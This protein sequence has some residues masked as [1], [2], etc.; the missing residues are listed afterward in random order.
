VTD[1]RTSLRLL[2]EKAR[3][4]GFSP[5]TSEASVFEQ[6]VVPLLRDVLG[7]RTDEITEFDRQ[8]YSRGAGIADGVLKL[9]GSPALYIEAKRIGRIPP[10]SELRRRA[11]FYSREEEQ[12]IRYARRSAAMR[13]GERWTVLTDFFRL[14]V[15]EASREERVLAF[16]SPEELEERFDEL[17]LLSRESVAGGRLH[18]HHIAERKPDIDTEFRDSLLHWRQRL[19]QQLYDSNPDRFQ[20]SGDLTIRDLQS[21]VQ[22]LLDRLIIIQFAAD[23]DAL[24]GDDPLRDLLDRVAP[25][26]GPRSLVQ[27]PSLRDALFAAFRRFDEFYNTSLF[28][29]GHVLESLIIE[30]AI[31]YPL[32]ESMAGQSFRRLDADILGT[33]YETYLGHRLR[34]ANGIVSMEGQVATRRA[35]GVY[36]T[37]V[38][39]VRAI[40]ERTVG[41]RLASVRDASEVDDIKVLDPACGSGSFLIQAFDRFAEW[42]EAENARR[43]TALPIAPTMEEVAAGPIAD[44]GRRILENNL[45]GVDLDPEAIELAAVN[46]ILQ[47]MRRGT[48]GVHLGRLPLILGQNLKVGNSLVPGYFR[49]KPMQTSAE[50]LASAADARKALQRTLH[51]SDETLALA[52][53]TDAS[54]AAS[55]AATAGMADEYPEIETRQPFWWEAEFPEVFSRAR[56]TADRG[57]AVVVGNPPWIG[58]QG[59]VQDRSYLAR[60]YESATGRFDIYVPFLELASQLTRD[61]G[62]VGMVTPSTYFL[63]D[64]GRT[65]RERLRDGETIVEII[66]YGSRQLF[67][68]ATNYPAIIILRRDRP[69]PTHEVLYVLD[70]SVGDAAQPHRQA[71]LRSEGWVFWSAAEAELFGHVEALA[72]TEPLEDICRLAGGSSGL[73]EGVV[74]GQNAVFLVD[75]D[76][77][78]AEGFEEDVMRPCVKGTD[79]ERWSVPPPKRQLIYPYSAGTVLSEDELARRPNVHR[80]LDAHRAVASPAGGL[81]GR[82]YMDGSTKRWYELWNQRSEALLSAPKLLTPE[83]GSRPKFALVDAEIA[84]TDSVTSA[85]PSRE[86]GYCREYLAGILNSRLMTLLHARMSVPKANGYLIF[87]PAFLGRLPIRRPNLDHPKDRRLHKGMVTHV[88]ECTELAASMRTADLDFQQY[89]TAYTVTDRTLTK[90]LSR[91]APEQRRSLAQVPGQLLA[92]AARREG[93][94]LVVTG[95]AKT[96]SLS[97]AGSHD[98]A[99]RDLLRLHV[100]EPLASFLEL[101]LP[102]ATKFHGRPNRHRTLSSRAS[103]MLLPDMNEA[104]MQDAVDKYAAEADRVARAKR[105]LEVLEGEI[106]EYVAA[107][108]ELTPAMADTVARFVLP[109][110]ANFSEAVAPDAAE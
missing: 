71:A 87:R 103:E 4:R 69:S 35:A 30:D 101:Y 52:N 14:R 44:Y 109:A 62:F 21:A 93:A 48:P 57:F 41:V 59:D 6:L 80:W 25:A 75:A 94:W 10:V 16:E 23:V 40:A 22:R 28:A 42:Y 90:V 105:R 85:T 13:E 24:E 27:P 29:P 53:A 110:D 1:P 46:L 70:S 55:A 88:L 8:T 58:F 91:L 66:D 39:V 82:A 49:A 43:R 77:A 20:E 12:A 92:L 67:E 31:L 64:Y 63:R 26:R 51:S 32:L 33:T 83:I 102:T 95:R 78:K 104:Q 7:W 65:L 50:S 38:D 9:A 2:I 99:W 76:V 15:F 56:N 108:Y 107:L 34:V 17:T 18:R 84:F 45:Y 36:Y 100:P 98:V 11:S 96:R 79:V 61:G 89:V 106:D 5:A 86:S 60:N 81:A 97:L 74:T 47:A 37:P 72:S 19:A 73:A 54:A 68:G 3:T